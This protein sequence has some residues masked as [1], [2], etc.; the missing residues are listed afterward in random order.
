MHTWLLLL[1]F[2]C[3]VL[4]GKLPVG[5]SKLTKLSELTVKSNLLTGNIPKEYSTLIN[6]S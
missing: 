6:L 2:N 4:S 3:S 5:Y 1:L